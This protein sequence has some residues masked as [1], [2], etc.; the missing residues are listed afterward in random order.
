[1]MSDMHFM[2]PLAFILAVLLPV[3]VALYFLRLRREKHTVSSV[4][5]WQEMVRDVA[6]NTPW[7]RLR[8]NWLLVLQLLFL[9][10]L[11]F[12]L[13]RP[14]S[15]TMDSGGGHLI[16][17]M[18]V[19]ASMAASDVHPDRL[20][21]AVE[22][23]HRLA[24]GLPADVPVTLV[25]AGREARVLLST[26]RERDRLNR[27]L[28][29]LRAAPGGADMTTALELA[30]AVASSESEVQVVI[31]SDGGVEI[32]D[33]L[34]HTAQVRY[35]SIGESDENQAISALSLST[36]T[37]GRGLM[38]FIRITNLSHQKVERRLTLH[39]IEGKLVTARDLALPAGDALALTIPDLPS[40]MTAIEA[41]LE[42][43]DA[44]ALDD[45]AWA[46]APVVSGAQ[47]QIVGP[48]NR[49][50]E[51]ALGLLPNV[52]VDAVSLA[53]YEVTLSNSQSMESSNRLTIFDTVLP[54]VGHYV[55]GADGH[56]VPGADGHYVPGADGRY[57]PGSLLFIAPPR[58]TEFFSVT[59]T[60]DS[61]TPRPANASEGLLRYVD[62]RQVV[63]QRA[64]R[65]RLPVWGRPV[66]VA[67]GG[68]DEGR[69]APLLVVGEAD[70]R[71]LAVLAFDL[72]Q[73]DLPL[74]V[75]FPLLLA[76]LVDLLAP[77]TAGST[78]EMVGPGQPLTIPLPPQAER[79]S[80]TRPD[81]TSESLPVEGGEALFGGTN[82]LGVYTVDWETGEQR[83]PLGRFAVNS[84]SLRESDIVPR[85][86]LQVANIEDKAVSAEKPTRR[87]WWSMFAWAALALLI[88][89]WLAQY[90]GG[91]T[92][93]WGRIS[94][95]VH[96]TR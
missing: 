60:L 3:I 54:T 25:V 36:D 32:P 50:L 17:V 52:Q 90:R 5:L 16:L 6:A 70:G 26:S 57:P 29:G 45:R 53:T 27:A 77:G 15:W 1:M 58:S 73:S 39:T 13:A 69:T 75:A 85:E 64:A 66:L 79:A 51:T 81:G 61:P 22:T 18:D 11:I 82:A 38:A 44:L 63:V 71:R 56:Y 21:V 33:R 8:V 24:D 20:G 49:F 30:A 9:I 83:W 94:S 93:V 41:R 95:K 43:A 65:L 80:I 91:I 88:G 7:Q 34:G 92:W 47:I 74:Q 40:D 14:F 10:A 28:N 76:N 62:L 86:Q 96:R 72:R 87:E 68:T 19:S 59:G 4:Y 35:I 89:E 31:L 23:A 78:P 48:G 12:A 67:A 42:G 55:P 2:I 37:A 46:V 84:F